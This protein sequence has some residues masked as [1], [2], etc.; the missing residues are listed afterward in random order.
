M[1][2]NAHRAALIAVSLALSLTPVYTARPRI[3]G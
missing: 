1:S 2:Y 3:R